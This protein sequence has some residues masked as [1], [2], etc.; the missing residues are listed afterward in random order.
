MSVW[1]SI[2]RKVKRCQKDE[3]GDGASDSMTLC[4]AHVTL[5]TFAAGE[6]Y[7]TIKCKNSRIPLIRRT[8]QSYSYNED[9]RCAD[10]DDLPYGAKWESKEEHPLNLTILSIET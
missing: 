8:Y 7:V 2:N 9:S 4:E 3:N 6:S 10:A 1:G 5:G